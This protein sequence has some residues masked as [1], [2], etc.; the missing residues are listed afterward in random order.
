MKISQIRTISSKLITRTSKSVPKMSKKTL[1]KQRMEAL[2][3]EIERKKILEGNELHILPELNILGL[4]KW[5]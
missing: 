2:Q 3:R 4:P 5:M 1:A